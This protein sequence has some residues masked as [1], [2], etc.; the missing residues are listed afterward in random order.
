MSRKK[1]AAIAE[2]TVQIVDNG[3]Y[4]SLSGQTVQI[5]Q[6]TAAAVEG[7]VLYNLDEMPSRPQARF[8]RPAT[9]EVTGESTFAAVQRIALT[10]SGH[11][12]CL[13]FAS[14]KNPGGGFLGGSQ[15]QEESLARSSALHKC[16]QTQ[17]AGYYETNRSNNSCLY[18]DLAIVSPRVPFFRD[19]ENR[20]LSA[21]VLGTVIT[22]PAPNAGA[23]ARNEP[24]NRSKVEATLIRRAELVLRAAA[25]HEIDALVLGAWGCGV[26]RNTPDQV[27]DAFKQWLGNGQQYQHHFEN[28][29]FAV[30]DPTEKRQNYR[31]F[32]KAFGGEQRTSPQT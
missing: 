6:E 12:G 4:V 19:D 8:D 5:R 13:N 22:A 31:A 21:P 16:L 3:R 7:T 25:L 32:A 27:A 10:S 15:A 2:E 23:V 9:V 17:F 26:F 18:L 30:H 24:E 20:L 11:V 29:V 14:A 28:V 1:R